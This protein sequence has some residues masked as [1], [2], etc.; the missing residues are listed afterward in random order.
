M[1][2]EPDHL[3][4][5]AFYGEDCRPRKIEPLGS[6]GGFSGARFWRVSTDSRVLCLRRW[7]KENPSTEGLEFIQAVLWYVAREGFNLVPL[8]LENRRFGGYVQ[9]AGYLWELAPWMPGAADFRRHPTERKLKAAMLALAEFHR[10]AATFPLPAESLSRSPGI[11][12]RLARLQ[13]WMSGDLDRLAA[14]IDPGLWPEM[15]DRGRRVLG[16]FPTGAHRVLELLT[17]SARHEVELQ[18]CIR[19]IWHNHVLYQGSRVSGLIDFGSMRPENVA[20][21][22]ARLLGSMAGDDASLWKVGLDTY[23]SLRPLSGH[24]SELVRAFD[25]STILMAGLNW[26][27]WVFRQRRQFEH[28]AEVLDRVDGILVRLGS[29]A[30]R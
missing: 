30:A 17:R 18:P 28:P 8:P 25:Q 20:A 21:D 23:Q 16:L 14:A 13:G 11:C 1:T 10:A 4:V 9:H 12:D 22:V 19:D 5:L 29:L 27:D 24:E 15:A 2:D 7:P 6:A 3:Q 26:L